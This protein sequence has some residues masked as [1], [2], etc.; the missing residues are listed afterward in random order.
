VSTTLQTLLDLAP[1]FLEAAGNDVPNDMQGTSRLSEWAG[2]SSKA[3]EFVLCE[4]RHNPVM[5]C[6][7]TMIGRRYK[8]TVYQEGEFGELFDLSEDPGE[9]RN[10]WGDPDYLEL[11]NDLL[12]KFIQAQLA[13]ELMKMPR[14]SHA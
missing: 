5:P 11:K 8:I 6:A 3:R 7:V 1:T 13:S 14:V 12:H 2:E 9:V 4:N 10:L